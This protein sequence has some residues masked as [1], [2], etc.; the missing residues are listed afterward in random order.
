HAHP[1]ESRTPRLVSADVTRRA[2]AWEV[3]ADGSATWLLGPGD[4]C[5]IT[6]GSGTPVCVVERAHAF[7]TRE[8]ESGSE[9]WSAD[10]WL[11]R[12]SCGRSLGLDTAIG[13]VRLH[14]SRRV[15]PV[16]ERAARARNGTRENH[17][18]EQSTTS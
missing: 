5:L 15:R 4:A 12:L 8:V 14:H 18:H 17:S 3:L 2:V 6:T 16:E 7:V 9:R 10:G 11:N 1:S 13:V